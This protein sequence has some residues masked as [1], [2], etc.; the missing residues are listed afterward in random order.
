MAGTVVA[1]LILMK[2][3][4]GGLTQLNE[5]MPAEKLYEYH[6]PKSV[7]IKHKRNYEAE[8]NKQKN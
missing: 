1:D 2:P 3:D 8:I 5:P 7:L 4:E 6:K